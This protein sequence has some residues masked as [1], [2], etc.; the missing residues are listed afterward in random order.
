MQRTRWMVGLVLGWILTVGFGTVG[1][2][3]EQEKPKLHKGLYWPKKDP[4][5]LAPYEPSPMEV[6]E[7]MLQLADVGKDDVVYDLGSGDGRIVITAAKEYGA[8]A[9]GF[10]IDP[11]LVA[12]SRA[13][14]RK[15]G[16]EQLVE[17]RE[18]DIMT[19][20]FSEATVVTLY[21]L[22]ESNLKL[23]P[24][25]QS[26]LRPGARI[27]SNDFDMDDWHPVKIDSLMDPDDN[28]FT[29]MLWEIGKQP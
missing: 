13:N 23:R 29:L 19:V 21:L 18:Q 2:T 15:A 9:V 24:R 17:I 27:V 7:R 3:Q 22:P 20:D 28:E 26:Q 5:Q 8:R 11:E 10:E 25:L 4:R 6:V 1:H 16:V 14:V 12:L